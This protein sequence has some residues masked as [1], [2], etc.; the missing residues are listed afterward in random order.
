MYSFTILSIN[1]LNNISEYA[2]MQGTAR[3]EDVSV[4]MDTVEKNV[5]A[6]T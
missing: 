3:A 5:N 6:M 2:T 4:L 1:K